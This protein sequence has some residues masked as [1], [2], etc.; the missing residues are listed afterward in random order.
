VRDEVVEESQRAFL[1][2][3]PNLE[4]YQIITGNIMVTWRT[5]MKD[6]HLITYGHPA[7]RNGAQT[8]GLMLI[9]LTSVILKDSR[10][11]FKL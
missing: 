8:T 4:T 5:I 2:Y 7:S 9:S 3:G 11:M 10:K 1:V 6:Y